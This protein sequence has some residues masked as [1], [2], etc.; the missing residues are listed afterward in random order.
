MVEITYP[1]LLGVFF[2]A[3]FAIVGT[4]IGINLGMGFS[5]GVLALIA[6]YFLMKV[7][8]DGNK[9][10]VSPVYIISTSM[11]SVHYILGTAILLCERFG[12][13]L[14]PWLTPP[15]SALEARV[16]TLDVWIGP[17]LAIFAVMLASTMLGLV[18]TIALHRKFLEDERLV[19]PSL[20][21]SATFIDTF[22]KGGEEERMVVL[23]VAAGLA[24]SMFQQALSLLGINVRYIDVTP[25]LPYGAVFALS[26][27]LGF[28]AIG[29]IVPPNT[30]ITVLISDLPLTSSSHPT[31]SQRESCR[32]APT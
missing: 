6:F 27:S 13:E 11:L 10:G 31:R 18:Y 21:A 25:Y 26:L 9:G 24:V 22:F 30:S 23:S 4:Y 3:V 16:L 17:L 28:M 15:R 2:I 29:Y 7:S 1:V 5:F 14:P 32:T 12:S 8:G 20:A 19:F